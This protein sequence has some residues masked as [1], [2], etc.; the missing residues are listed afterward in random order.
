MVIF[1]FSYLEASTFIGEDMLFFYYPATSYLCTALAEGRFPLWT[2]AVQ[3]GTPFYTD[4]QTS[5]YLPTA[6]NCLSKPTNGTSPSISCWAA[7]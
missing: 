6:A 5:V 3:H 7:G 2:A 4:I 1:D